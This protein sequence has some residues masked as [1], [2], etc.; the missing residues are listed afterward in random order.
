MN[1]HGMREFRADAKILFSL[2]FSRGNRH[3]TV[4]GGRL[5]QSGPRSEGRLLRQPALEIL[6]RSARTDSPRQ[7][8]FQTGRIC[9]QRI[10]FEQRLF[11]GEDLK[12]EYDD[13]A[14]ISSGNRGKNIGDKAVDHH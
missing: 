7:N 1:C 8:T 13:C 5:C 3:I 6:T 10:E 9:V 4:G 2:C 11:K 12:E 14:M